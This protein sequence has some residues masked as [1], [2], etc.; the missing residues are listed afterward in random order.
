MQVW[1][2]QSQAYYVLFFPH[3]R[4]DVDQAQRYEMV[5]STDPHNVTLLLVVRFLESA[6]TSHPSQRDSS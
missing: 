3:G 2:M 4:G 1:T 6:D 5:S